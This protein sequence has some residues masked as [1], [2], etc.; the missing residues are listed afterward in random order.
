MAAEVVRGDPFDHVVFRGPRTSTRRLHVYLDGDG[1]P[2]LGGLP[3]GDP[4][5][6]EHLVLTLMARDPGATIYVGRPCYHGMATAPRCAGELWTSHRYSE[7]V[8][9]SMAAALR[10]LLDAGGAEQVAWLGYSGGG[11][12][13][14]LLA[15]RIPETIAVVTVAANLDITAWAEARGALPLT[16]SLNPA[17]QPPLGPDVYQRHYAGA[18]DRI[19]PPAVVRAGAKGGP[20]VVIPDFDHTCCW[21]TLWER[22]LGDLDRALEQG[23]DGHRGSARSSEGDAH[24]QA[25]GVARAVAVADQ[26]AEAGERGGA[27]REHHGD[28]GSDVDVVAV[29]P[30][31]L[32]AELLA[33]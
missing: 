28:A 9:A 15:A 23:A 13:A 32:E 5:P 20:V 22:V 18:R 4:T 27:A 25:H 31:G 26:L 19:V 7:V 17:R 6:R 12:L 14:V 29:G 10:R 1:T 16:G 2:W 8:V 3:A 33:R 21:A 30:I 11:V 24:S